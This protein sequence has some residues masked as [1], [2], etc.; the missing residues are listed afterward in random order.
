[1]PLLQPAMPKPSLPQY[2]YSLLT[3]LLALL[4]G[5][6]LPTL[7]VPKTDLSTKTALITGSNSGIGLR[8]A[9]DL[10]REHG[11]GKVYLACRNLDKAAKAARELVAE[12]STSDDDVAAKTKRVECL[13]L[14]TSSLVSVRAFAEEWTENRGDERIDIVIHNTGIG[15]ATGDPITKEG[16]PMI[17]VTNFLGSFLLTFLMEG[18][19]GEG[20]RVILTSSTG[21]FGGRFSR[22]FRLKGEGQGKGGVVEEGWHTPPP[23]AG[24]GSILWSLMGRSGHGRK[25]D[26][27]SAQY[28]NSKA[29]QVAF[30]KLLQQHFDRQ[31]L[32]QGNSKDVRKTAHAFSPGFTSTPIFDKVTPQAFFTDPLFWMLRFSSGVL[33]TDVGQGAA[34]GV[35]LASTADEGVVGRV[36]GGERGG[37]AGGGYLDRMRRKVSAVDYFYGEGEGKGEEMLERFWV[38]WERD[39][40]VEWR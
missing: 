25:K 11:I 27:N 16:L 28:A 26:M 21:H 7:H 15:S 5:R 39:A 36:G 19:L 31:F 34:T 6:L 37:G 13:V 38:R 9:R 3:S 33:A 17:Y 8:I 14:D 30:A 18:F 22:D 35:W 40:E 1:M 10:L 12:L 20:A 23:R 24:K 29:M 2:L 4:T 32:S